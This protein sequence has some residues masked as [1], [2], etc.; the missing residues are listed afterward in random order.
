MWS[1]YLCAIEKYSPRPGKCPSHKLTGPV[2]GVPG[3]WLP[4][5]GGGYFNLLCFPFQTGARVFWKALGTPTSGG[6]VSSPAAWKRA[7]SYPF[8]LLC[9]R[10][11]Y[12]LLTSVEKKKRPVATS[13]LLFSSWFQD[14]PPP[15]FEPLIGDLQG[16]DGRGRR[17]V[18]FTMLLQIGSR[19]PSLW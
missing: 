11:R 10:A 3:T 18:F 4:V 9:L 15:A 8:I 5:L 6:G 19:Y 13:Q 2:P 17:R 14:P 16:V 7:T 12:M 1:D